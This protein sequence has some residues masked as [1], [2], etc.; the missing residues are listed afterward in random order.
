MVGG[1]AHRVLPVLAAPSIA[2]HPCAVAGARAIAELDSFF[3]GGEVGLALLAR[4]KL[5]ARGLVLEGLDEIGHLFAPG[6]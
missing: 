4:G 2:K 3:D 5:D 1:R 6:H